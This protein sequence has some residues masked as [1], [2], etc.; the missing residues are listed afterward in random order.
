[1]LI[2]FVLDFMPHF[3]RKKFVQ[4]SSHLFRF[5]CCLLVLQ[6]LVAPTLV[7]AGIQDADGKSAQLDVT[8]Q[9]VEAVKPA[10]VFSGNIGLYS[11]YAIRGITY[12]REKPAVQADVQYDHPSGWYLGFWV[13]NVDHYSINGGTMETD[14]YGGF[15]GNVGDVTYDIGLWHWTFAGASVPI[16]KVTYDTLE[17]YFGLAYKSLNFRY[18]REMTDYFGVGEKSAASD[19]G[20]VPNGS[21]RESTYSEVNFNPELLMGFTLQLHAARQ[22]VRHYE[23]MNF[24]DYRIGIE[25]D[26][27]DGIVV[28]LAHS[29]TTANSAVFTDG[30]GLDTSRP[31]WVAFIRKNF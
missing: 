15:I 19:F 18:W 4:Y 28:N 7:E 2:F 1:M 13:S 14:P 11:Q 26:L 23:R 25:K 20:L 29:E 31:K 8:G 6:V 9:R 10:G 3:K 16:S 5:A 30:K 24:N 21:S 27:G 12:S 17:A 22:V